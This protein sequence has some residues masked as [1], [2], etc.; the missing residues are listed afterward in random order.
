MHW[1]GGAVWVRL[2]MVAFGKNLKEMTVST[3]PFRTR[4]DHRKITRLKEQMDTR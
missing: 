3:Q 2:H 1:T 4:R